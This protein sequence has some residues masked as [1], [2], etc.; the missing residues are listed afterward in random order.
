MEGHEEEGQQGGAAGR[1]GHAK[2]RGS[3]GAGLRWGRS[4]E[5]RPT[6]EPECRPKGSRC[7]SEVEPE[8]RKGPGLFPHLGGGAGSLMKFRAKTR[9][10]KSEDE[11]REAA[12]QRW[13][14]CGGA[15]CGERGQNQSRL[16]GQ[17]QRWAFGHPVGRCRE[18]P[19]L[20]W[21][22]GVCLL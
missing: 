1:R 9:P 4:L 6:A 21:G 5:C 16:W 11:R 19:Q 18:G 7:E 8:W 10:K 22:L 3:G 2:G 15:P 14:V 13:C 17:S 12:S 20:G